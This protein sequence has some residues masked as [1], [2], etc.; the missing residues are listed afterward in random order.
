MS[1]KMISFW[2][3]V[4]GFTGC[5]LVILATFSIIAAA[6]LSGELALNVLK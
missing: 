1:E 5:S 6:V 2:V 4:Y 3:W